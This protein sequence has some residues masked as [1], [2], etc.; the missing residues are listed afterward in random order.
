MKYEFGIEAG[1]CITRDGK[2]FVTIG[3][4]NGVEPCDAD[5]FARALP[6]MVRLLGELAEFAA[7]R[8]PGSLA[9][10]AQR[11]AAVERAR[12][13]LDEIETIRP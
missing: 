7:D 9:Q 8:Q 4:V 6:E 11:N 3:R 12:E 5:D 13:I 1:R 10:E 2:P